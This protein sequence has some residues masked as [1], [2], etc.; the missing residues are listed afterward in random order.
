MCRRGTATV[1]YTMRYKWVAALMV[2]MTST[3]G[4]EAP[5]VPGDSVYQLKVELTA[6][7]GNTS[8]LEQFRGHPVLISMFYATCGGVCP[9]IAST[10]RRIES[11]LTP[12]E[13]RALRCVMVSFD[14]ERDDT[15]ALT[16]FARMNKLDDP[17]W[18]VARTQPSS[19]G[20]LAAVL[21]VRYRKLPDQSFGHS[22]IIAVLD[23]DG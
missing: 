19:V 22:T 8:R 11:A 10:M 4:A 9:T 6:S 5:V 23:A 20:D 21:G 16:E 12:E 3:A 14:P 1:T 2:V 13:Q 17:H 18:T 7:D 15:Q